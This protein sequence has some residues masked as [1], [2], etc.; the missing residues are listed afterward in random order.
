MYRPLCR[1][2]STP[3]TLS[4]SQRSATVPPPRGSLGPSRQAQGLPAPQVLDTLLVLAQQPQGPLFFKT[5]SGTN[6][7]EDPDKLVTL[8]TKKAIKPRN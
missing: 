5:V 6:I 2:L 8:T 3:K 4:R 1:D 7:I